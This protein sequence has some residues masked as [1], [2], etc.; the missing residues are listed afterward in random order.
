MLARRVRRAIKA[1]PASRALLAVRAILA[2][3]EI[4]VQQVLR[5]FPCS[6]LYPLALEVFQ[7]FLAREVLEAFRATQATMAKEV[8]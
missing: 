5:A 7:Y 8:L 2:Q 3:L 4:A 1:F 6:Y